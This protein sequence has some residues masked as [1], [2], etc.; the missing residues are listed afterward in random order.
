V[1]VDDD[2]IG[3]VSSGQHAKFMRAAYPFHKYGMLVGALRTVASDVS[4]PTTQDPKS[5]VQA[6]LGFRAVV[7]LDTQQ[8]QSCGQPFVLIPAMHEVAQIRQGELLS[9]IGA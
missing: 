1:R 3:F 5:P 9:Q 7:A 8:L 6:N 2:Y 4:G